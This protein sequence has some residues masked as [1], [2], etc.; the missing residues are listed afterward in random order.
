MF[1]EHEV[2]V[3]VPIAGL[4]NLLLERFRDAEALGEPVYRKGEE[5]RSKVGPEQPFAKEVV[6]NLGHPRISHAGLA[7]P[8]TWRATGARTLFPR[9]T[10]ELEASRASVTT[11]R[12]RLRASY[13]PPFGWI[14]D[15]VDRLLLER[16]A[17]MTVADWLERVA[18]NLESQSAESLAIAAE[19]DIDLDD[20]AHTGN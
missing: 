20:G 1:V 16:V 6:L 14:G 12:L 2:D 11:S 13:D 5:I 3:R 9:L 18:A 10:G 4:E 15:V 19:S 7:V 8:L 17:R